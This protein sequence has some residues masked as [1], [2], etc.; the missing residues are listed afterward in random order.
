MFDNLLHQNVSQL[1][2]QDITSN[3]LPGAILFSGPQSSGKLTCA[4]EVTRILSCTGSQKGKWT[5]ECNSCLQHKSLVSS[6]IILLGSKDCLPEIKAASES[7]ILAYE[8]NASYLTATRYLFLRSVRKLT[9]RFNPILWE[10]ATNLNKIANIISTIDE[11]LELIDFPRQLPEKEE[12]I[13]ICEELQKQCEKLEKDFL[14]NS[15]PIN[16]VRNLSVWARLKTIEGK[17]TIII[18]NA[19]KMLENVR[20]ALLKILE[21]PPKDT[22]FIL[23][24]CNRNLIM[25]TILSR[26]RT[27]NFI[28]R[29]TNAQNEVISRVFHKKDF[30]GTINEFLMTYF[31][32]SPEVLKSN[33]KDFFISIANNQIPNIQ[34]VIK[35]CNNFNPKNMLKIFLDGIASSQKKLLCTPQGTQ[36]SVQ[37]M[38]S[39]RECYNNISIYN[40]NIESAFENLFRNLVKINKMNGNVFSC[41][42]T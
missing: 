10:K 1:L 18:E 24:T 35:N 30:S 3:K 21:E 12:L 17:K 14:Y 7:F 39:I 28:E 22:V 32:I 9:L 42:I 8:Q 19:D 38:D 5:C 4:L 41:V 23:T 37:I 40:Q 36:A 6:N 34:E 15:I 2:K 11:Q 20:N 26:V 33:A 25:P 16:H 29:D 27:Y 31:P 13:K